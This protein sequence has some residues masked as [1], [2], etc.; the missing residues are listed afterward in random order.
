M[1][2]MMAN[3]QFL[4]KAAVDKVVDIPTM[5]LQKRQAFRKGVLCVCEHVW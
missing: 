4:D 5:N 1:D 2:E 3:K